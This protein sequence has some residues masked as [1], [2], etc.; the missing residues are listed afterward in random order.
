MFKYRLELTHEELAVLLYD[1]GRISHEKLDEACKGEQNEVH[2]ALV[3][4][5]VGLWI[6]SK[7]P[8]KASKEAVWDAI[9]AT[10]KGR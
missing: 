1:F 4:R 2:F 5:I 3:N 6:G 7:E 10:A 9:N 8:A